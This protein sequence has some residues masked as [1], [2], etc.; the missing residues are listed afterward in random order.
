[1]GNPIFLLD[2]HAV[3]QVPRVL[4]WIVI[5]VPGKIKKNHRLFLVYALGRGNLIKALISHTDAQRITLIEGGAS[6]H[7]DLLSD[8]GKVYPGKLGN[9]LRS[10]GDTWASRNSRIPNCLSCRDTYNGS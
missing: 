3:D 5:F 8:S 1:M 9:D 4:S 6:S 2:S 7:T 10:A